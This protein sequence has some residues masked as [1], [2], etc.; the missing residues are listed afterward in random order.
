MRLI[1][2]SFMRLFVTYS[3][4][5]CVKKYR[6]LILTIS[7]THMSGPYRGVLLSTS[8]YDVGNNLFYLT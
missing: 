4:S 7:Y 3:I 8:T 1:D 2:K 6:H 5:G